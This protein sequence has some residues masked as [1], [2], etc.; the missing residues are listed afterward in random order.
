MRI[1]LLNRGIVKPVLSGHSKIDKFEWPLKTG[2]TVSYFLDLNSL[3]LFP[4]TVKMLFNP[5]ILK[6]IFS[7]KKV[8]SLHLMSIFNV[9]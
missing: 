3:K 8:C 6:S 4:F 5:A 2:F 9:S 1:C 7:M